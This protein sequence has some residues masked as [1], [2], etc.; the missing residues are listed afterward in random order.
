M[1]KTFGEDGFALYR[2]PHGQQISPEEF[3]EFEIA[4]KSF[5]ETRKF[6]GDVQQAVKES[7]RPV[8]FLDGTTDVQY[9]QKAAECLRKQEILETIEL[10]DGGGHGRLDGIFNKFDPKLSEII[11]QKVILLHDCDKTRH[12]TKG[13]VFE[14]N[15]PKQENHPLQTGIE[16]LFEKATLE[17]AQKYR[18]AFFNIDSEHEKTVRGKREIVPERWGINKDEKTNL[19]DWL[20]EN[21]TAEDFKHFQVL[22]DQLEEILIKDKEA[23]T[24]VAADQ[25]H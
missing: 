7:Q 4:Y 14:R 24:A 22:F 6:L 10:R 3:S 23:T 2:L 17:R 21:G 25:S 13:K 9:L 19:C 15:I 8:I 20:C 12:K 1:G 18:E 16:N 11:P 5:T